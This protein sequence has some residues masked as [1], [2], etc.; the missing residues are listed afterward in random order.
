MTGI[1]LAPSES[2]LRS[3]STACP[4]SYNLYPS[5]LITTGVATFQDTEPNQSVQIYSM[6]ASAVRQSEHEDQ[7]MNIGGCPICP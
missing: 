5:G 1:F 6:R 4:Q 7:L 3:L 2:C